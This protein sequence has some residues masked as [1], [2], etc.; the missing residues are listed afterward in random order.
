M[1]HSVDCY[2]KAI[3]LTADSDQ[4]P[5]IK[6]LKTLYPSKRFA[7]LPPIGRGAKDLGRVCHEQFKMTEAHLAACQLAIPLPVIREGKPTGAY[8]VKPSQWP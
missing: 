5:V 1:I 2:D 8:L 4:V 3:L 7:N 6:L